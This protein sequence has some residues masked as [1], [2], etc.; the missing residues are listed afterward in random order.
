VRWI[1][2]THAHLDHAAGASALL[3]RC[4]KATLVAH[5]R[6]ARHLVD[7]SRLVASATAVYGEQT[8]R[9]LYGSIEPV[10][11]E[12]VWLADHGSSVELGDCKLHFLHTRGH[13]NHHM[14]AFDPARDTVYTGDTFGL[15]YPRLQRAGRFAFYSSSP[16]DFDAAEARKSID[17]I[18]GLETKTAC[19]THFGEVDQLGTIAEQLRGWIDLSE[20][21][22]GRYGSLPPA[23]AEAAFANELERAMEGAVARRGLVPDEEDRRLLTMDLR[24]NAQGLVVAASRR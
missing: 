4:P 7:P 3:A 8:F 15:V 16:T 10:P 20:D 2:V 19:P 21:L 17:R 24:L 12:R 9:E 6:A 23:E 1:V 11:A 5:P 13:A 18:M 14:V 22:L